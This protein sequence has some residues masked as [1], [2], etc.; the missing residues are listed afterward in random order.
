MSAVEALAGSAP[1]SASGSQQRYD[2]TRKVL[3]TDLGVAPGRI[4][5]A[6]CAIVQRVCEVVGTR[7]ARLSATAVAVVLKQTQ[8]SPKPGQTIQIGVDGS[9]VEHYPLFEVGPRGPSI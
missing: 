8:A 5:D 2:A 3:E 9:V 4:T 6:D 1:G 7:A